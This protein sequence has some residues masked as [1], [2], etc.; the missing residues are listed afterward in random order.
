MDPYSAAMVAAAGAQVV[1]DV[2]SASSSRK[3]AQK[4]RDFQERMSGTAHQREVEDLIAAG[5]NPALSAMRGGGASTPSGA[6]AQV[7]DYG[8]SVGRGVNTALALKRQKAEIDLLE[9]QSRQSDAL[10]VKTNQEAETAFGLRGGQYDLQRL[11]IE[12]R[13]KMMPHLIDQAREAVRQTSSSARQQEALAILAELDKTGRVNLAAFEKEIGAMGPAG[14][15]LLE[16]LRS[17]R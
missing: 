9:S 3:E 13:E 8:G 7:P 11:D 4:N 1:G 2:W 15:Y 5:L 17:V 12:Q 6:V 16:I 14:R 10:T